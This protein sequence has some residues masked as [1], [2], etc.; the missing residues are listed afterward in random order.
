[1]FEM[2]VTVVAALVASL[3]ALSQSI[4]MNGPYRNYYRIGAI[5]VI[6]FIYLG[7]RIYKYVRNAHITRLNVDVQDYLYY[8]RFTSIIYRC[9][10]FISY[11]VQNLLFDYT[12]MKRNFNFCKGLDVY[13]GGVGDYYVKFRNTWYSYM[14]LTMVRHRVSLK[15][16]QAYS[17]K[18]KNDMILKGMKGT[19][20][21]GIYIAYRK[22][23]ADYFDEHQSLNRSLMQTFDNFS[24]IDSYYYKNLWKYYS[25]VMYIKKHEPKIAELV[26]RQQQRSH[27]DV[28][29]F[30]KMD[31]R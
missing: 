19:E 17:Q 2:F 20:K 31:Y 16:L 6:V 7:S 14:A 11:F 1:M 24:K 13:D 29:D 3:Y 10:Y 26:N 8:H 18:I 4:F 5:A 22:A 15:K 21:E 25:A 12:Y 30:K 23:V 27:S 28:N 9:G